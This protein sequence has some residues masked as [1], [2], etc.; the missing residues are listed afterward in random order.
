MSDKKDQKLN[1]PKTEI[2]M[3]ANLNERE[4]KMLEEWSKRD[5]YQKIR[6]QNSGKEK[7]ILHDGPP[8]A[9]GKIHIGHA[10]NKVLKD[11]TIKSKTL[12]GLDAPFIPGWDCHGL[13]IELN[14]EKKHG[15][16]S[17]LVSNKETFQK[18]C[19]EYAELQVN[20]QRDDFK[21]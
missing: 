10:V 15:K 14:V 2:P 12:Q 18:A 8:Y 11:I 6:K 19:K 16:N 13:P 17:D 9:N 20:N 1:L 4:P 7:F 21:G 5:V 3:K